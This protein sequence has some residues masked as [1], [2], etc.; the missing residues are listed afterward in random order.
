MG[1][2]ESQAEEFGLQR[3]FANITQQDDD[4]EVVSQEDS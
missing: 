3:P 4:R 1:V 2:F